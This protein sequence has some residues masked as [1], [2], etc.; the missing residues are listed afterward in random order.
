MPSIIT[1]NAKNFK[2]AFNR[3]K[4]VSEEES[5][6]NFASSKRIVWKF[7]VEK[8]PWMGG[9]YE[10]LVRDIKLSLKKTVRKSLLKYETVVV[11]IEGILN[12]RPLI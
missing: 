12:S 7:I 8:A 3:I 2:A 5:V 10:R 6:S 11:E 9:F 4:A 1:D